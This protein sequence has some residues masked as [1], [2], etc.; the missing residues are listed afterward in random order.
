MN[1]Y[2][3]TY[4]GVTVDVDGLD[5]VTIEGHT[6]DGVVVVK[7]ESQALSKQAFISHLASR[8]GIRSLTFECRRVEA[9]Q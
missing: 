9:I 5:G 1:H 2:L 6:F 3:Y 7:S 4:S 8:Y